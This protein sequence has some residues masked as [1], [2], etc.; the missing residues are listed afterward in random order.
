MFMGN[1]HLRYEQKKIYTIFGQ[2]T[3]DFYEKYLVLT[4]LCKLWSEILL[5]P[6]N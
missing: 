3:A 1:I 6:R 5:T 2:N 4:M